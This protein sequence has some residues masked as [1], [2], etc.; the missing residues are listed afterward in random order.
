MDL[1][2]Q[3]DHPNMVGYKDAFIVHCKQDNLNLKPSK[4]LCIIMEY[5]DRLT[6]YLSSITPHSEAIF[7]DIYFKQ[8]SQL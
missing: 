6:T 4:D 2:K 8:C 7:T 3:F 1:L 5:C